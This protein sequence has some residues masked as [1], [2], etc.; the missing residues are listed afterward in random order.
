MVQARKDLQR[1]DL[2][3]PRLGE[4]ARLALEFGAL[5]AAGG[6]HEGGGDGGLLVEE[7][8]ATRGRL[9]E[10]EVGV[11]AVLQQRREVEDPAHRCSAD[12]AARVEREPCQR[13]GEQGCGEVPARRMPAHHDALG[14]EPVPG[15]FAREPVRGGDHV[16]D[17]LLD[18]H[19]RSEAIAGK[20]HVHAGGDPGRRE[21]GE[22][23][24]VEGAPVAAVDEDERAARLRRGKKI[25]AMAR[26]G[27]V[28][29]VELA[30]KRCADESRVLLPSREKRRML[31]HQRAIVVLALDEIPIHFAMLHSPR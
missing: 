1:G 18:A 3:P 24:L 9:V 19:G 14:G 22:H 15:T 26:I 16:V 27:A 31:R 23:R 21:P 25:E 29:N 20:R 8:Q 2:R 6:D 11:E 4:E 17:D 10:P 5:R 30:R 7:V 28:G 13:R 12:D